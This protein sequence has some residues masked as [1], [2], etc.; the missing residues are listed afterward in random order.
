MKQTPDMM[1]YAAFGVT[2]L[3]PG[4]QYMVER[5]Q[6]ELDEFRGLIAQY[7]AGDTGKNPRRVAAG[8]KNNAW[9]GMTAAERSAEMKRRRAVGQR[10]NSAVSRWA[11]MTKKQ[12]EEWKQKMLAGRK[13]STKRVNGVIAASKAEHINGRAVA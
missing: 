3:V 13:K 10:R 6:R 7:Q 11:R 12:R 4:M 2:A 1:K 5:M 9:T 8:K